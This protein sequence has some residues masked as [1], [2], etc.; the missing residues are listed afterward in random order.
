MGNV[1][2]LNADQHGQ[3]KARPDRALHYAAGHHM[4]PISVTEIVAASADFPVFI[5]RQANGGLSL[6]MITSLVPAQNLFVSENKWQAGFQSAAMRTFPF[7]L[8]AGDKNQPV[9]AIDQSSE[10]LSDEHGEA[11]FTDKGKPALWVSQMKAILL[12]AGNAR[13][14]T[15]GFFDAL[16][17]LGLMRS[18]E[19]AVTFPG[20]EVSRI[21]GL[22]MINEDALQSLS[23]DEF[24]ML[25]DQ[26]FLAPIYAVMFSAFQLNRLIRMNNARGD[27]PY[28][29]NIQIEVAKNNRDI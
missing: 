8:I 20:D 12:E 5:S 21:T 22:S 27:L 10:I 9:L 26:G 19:I 14:I 29:S 23:K 2:A 3:L 28:I 17:N 24:T 6:S 4:L 11:L 15:H 13:Q 16:H 25:R 7:T 18:I 1:V